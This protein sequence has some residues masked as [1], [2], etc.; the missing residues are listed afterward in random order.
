MST[1]QPNSDLG[2]ITPST[3]VFSAQTP[4]PAEGMVLL[5]EIGLASHNDFIDIAFGPETRRFSKVIEGY[6]AVVA[7]VPRKA[8]A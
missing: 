5:G 8:L 4:F 2:A 7:S 1:G 6:V 3:E